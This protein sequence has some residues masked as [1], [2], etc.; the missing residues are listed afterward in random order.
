MLACG[1]SNEGRYF[2]LGV[3]FG[4]LSATRQGGSANIYGKHNPELPFFLKNFNM[5]LTRSGRYIPVNIPNII[6][7]GIAAYFAQGHSGAFVSTVVGSGQ[8]VPA[9]ASGLDVQ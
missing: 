3:Q 9:Q 4:A 7:E 1:I 5:R 6:T 8:D 2:L